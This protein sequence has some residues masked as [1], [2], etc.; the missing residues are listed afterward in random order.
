[1]FILTLAENKAN[2]NE[3]SS[4]GNTIFFCTSSNLLTDRKIIIHQPP[5]LT[6]HGAVLT[7]G[8]YTAENPVT[9]PGIHPGIA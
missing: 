2:A 7:I 8:C 4:K 5:S 3:P 1:M 6:E 9:A